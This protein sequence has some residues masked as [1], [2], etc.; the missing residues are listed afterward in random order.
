MGLKEKSDGVCPT[1]YAFG[2]MMGCVCYL[3]A[4]IIMCDVL[5]H[6]QCIACYW[7][8]RYIAL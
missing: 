1:L 8:K 3:V 7:N 5:K 4:G 2:F 6:T